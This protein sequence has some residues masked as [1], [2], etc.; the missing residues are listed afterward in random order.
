[1]LGPGS[2]TIRRYGLI[3]GSVSL[4]ERD[5]MSYM[6]K[7]HPVWLSLLLAACRLRHRT[8]FW[9]TR[10]QATMVVKQEPLSPELVVHQPLACP[11]PCPCPPLSWSKPSPGSEPVPSQNEKQVLREKKQVSSG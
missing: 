5:L 8:F 1:M 10:G 4:W 2:G 11:C 9:V 7:L 6:L 3:G